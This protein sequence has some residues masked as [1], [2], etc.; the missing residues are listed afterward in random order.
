M[1]T[2]L[3]PAKSRVASKTYLVNGAVLLVGILQ[4]V[5]DS[6]KLLPNVAV[7]VGMGIAIVNLVLREF[8]KQPVGKAGELVAVNPKEPSA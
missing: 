1:T 8:Q 3:V 2:V 7:W 4:I 5:L 6:G